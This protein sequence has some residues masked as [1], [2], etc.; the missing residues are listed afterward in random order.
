M[1]EWEI[2]LNGEIVTLE[3]IRALLAGDYDPDQL[4]YVDGTPITLG[5][6]DV[7]IQIE[8]Y[9]AYL[10]ETYFTPQTWSEEQLTSLASLSTQLRTS[11]ISLMSAEAITAPSGVSHNTKV[12]IDA[13]SYSVSEGGAVDV[14]VTV[15]GAYTDQTTTLSLRTVD[16]SA[17]AG[18][19]YTAI[20]Q[21]L[22]FEG[23][24][25]QTVT[26]TTQSNDESSEARS[27]AVQIYNVENAN[28]G[29]NQMAV[30]TITDSVDLE[31]VYNSTLTVSNGVET[32]IGDDKIGLLA[33][34]VTFD[35]MTVK[36]N[37]NNDFSFTLY[38]D[39]S[40][41][42]NWNTVSTSSSISSSSRDAYLD[43]WI[44][45]YADAYTSMT[46][47]L[48]NVTMGTD[49]RGVSG[50]WI[51]YYMHAIPW[52][53][54]A[55]Y[56]DGYSSNSTYSNLL[57]TAG[58]TYSL[59]VAA[60]D[61]LV[62]NPTVTV[63]VDLYHRYYYQESTYAT[64]VPCTSAQLMS[65]ATVTFTDSTAPTLT[66]V[67]VVY[68]TNNPYME[69]DLVPVVVTFSEPVSIS[70][71]P[72]VNDTAVT[73]GEGSGVFAK[74]H[75]FYY[76]VTSTS[77][78]TLSSISFTAGSVVD[79]AGNSMS[80]TTNSS[81]ST[82]V[83]RHI[84]LVDSHKTVTGFTAT[85]DDSD[86]ANPVMKVTANVNS[87]EDQTTWLGSYLKT[88]D[89]GASYIDT[90]AMYVSI[91]GGTTKYP[92]YAT[93][94]S[95]T[96]GTLT[97]TIPLDLNTSSADVTHMAELWIEN[98]LVMDYYGS[99]NLSPVIFITVEDI[100]T[101]ILIGETSIGS[102]T[103]EDSNNTI[104]VQE[105]DMPEMKA[106][107]TLKGSNFTYAG[108]DDLVWTSDNTDIANID[109]D[110]LITPTGSSGTVTFTL[111]A[112]NG[113][114]EDKTVIFTTDPISFTAGLTPF[115]TITSTNIQATAGQAVT[116][117]W[118]SNLPDKDDFTGGFTV[119]VTRGGTVTHTDTTTATS[120]TIPADNWP[121]TIR[122]LPT[123]RSP[124]QS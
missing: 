97:A 91:D 18:T 11:G 45:T 29:D 105:A 5:D 27:F 83:D 103:Y 16:G 9:I 35:T 40:I 122:P 44:V 42:S 80:A 102:Y 90:A 107:Y 101:D 7:M 85:V 98:K 75:T 48:G 110:G 111:T 116:L 31:S 74:E 55:N 3:D 96:G 38:S 104:Y 72:T 123:I 39:T 60:N 56:Y 1:S 63:A 37:L 115:L 109:Q 71:T 32:S 77:P 46:T 15:S 106:S 49:T 59:D 94:D 6:L 67:T 70:T 57:N 95:L 69:G 10:Q 36:E 89:D 112:S 76:P 88:D 86:S 34:G 108:A 13:A 17:E 41:R 21:T 64:T 25:T 26:I 58:K 73:H 119:S 50:Y 118:S 120:C 100:T 47:S 114:I 12:T 61:A 99:D 84:T 92:L 43:Y 8:D 78:N 22:T 79:L 30:V 68:D 24:G 82:S 124:S 14:K 2:K 66:G 19:D 51:E 65:N 81:F 121:M 62:N 87:I 28:Y 93:S 4:V 23:N 113:G 117:Y 54:Y 52:D 33:Q 53:V 20:S